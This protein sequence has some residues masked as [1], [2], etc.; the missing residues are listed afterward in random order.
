MQTVQQIVARCARGE[1]TGEQAIAEVAK[2]SPH[3]PLKWRQIGIPEYRWWAL[4][5][6]CPEL[7]EAEL[8]Q[9]NLIA[10]GE[11]RQRAG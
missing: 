7:T 10:R 5:K 1:Q 11:R 2:L 8:H 9:A 6:L 3:T 4:F